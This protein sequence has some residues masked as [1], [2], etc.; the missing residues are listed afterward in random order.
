[1]AMRQTAIGRLEDWLK[2]TDAGTEQIVNIRSPSVVQQQI[3]QDAAS[4]V[5]YLK[6][7]PDESHRLP[8]LVAYITKLEK[9]RNNYILDYLPEYGNILTTAGYSNTR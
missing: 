4:Y 6:H 3:A 2:Q 5:E 1:M 9:S 7:Q 8:D